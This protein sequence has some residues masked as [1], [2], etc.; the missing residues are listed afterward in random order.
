MTQT[1]LSPISTSP[2]TEYVLY[3]FETNPMQADRLTWKK[4]SVTT[5]KLSALSA[6]QKLSSTL[7]YKRVE[8][9]EHNKHTDTVIPI[10][11]WANESL[12]QKLKS[13]INPTIFLFL[14]GFF[15]L[16]TL[17]LTFFVYF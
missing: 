13:M 11:E 4:Q 7:K 2:Q 5:N 15:I 1:N 17:I 16:S 9:H 10:Y 6:G 14:S 3:T 8:L 12:S